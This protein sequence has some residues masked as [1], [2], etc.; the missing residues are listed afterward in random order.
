[1]L[2]SDSG[3]PGVVLINRAHKVQ[4]EMQGDP[5]YVW[6]ESGASLGLVARQAATHG[7][8]G[9]EWACGIPG[10]VGGAIFGNAGAHGYDMASNLMVADILHLTSQVNMDQIQASLELSGTD[11]PGILPVEQFSAQQ[12]GFAYRTS[13]F[14]RQ[15]VKARMYPSIV[16]LSAK[17]SLQQSTSHAVQEKIEVFTAYRRRTQPPGASLGSMFK[18]PPGDYA[19]RLIESVGLKGASIGGAQISPLH[20]NFF[21]N[22]ANATAADVYSLIQLARETVYEK[23]G[24]HLELE[25]EL[26]GEYG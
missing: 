26:L 6:V 11:L 22:Q 21:V 5:P 8:S 15:Q 1:V 24:I 2:I 9:L 14:K 12:C 17:L 4:F 13:V 23:T 20:G 16:I 19:G 3:L 7:L 25:I 10:T 18:N